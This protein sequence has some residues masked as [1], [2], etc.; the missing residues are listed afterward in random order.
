MQHA[1]VNEL[2]NAITVSAQAL[3]VDGVPGVRFTIEGP[4]SVSE[5]FVTRAEAQAVYEELGRVLS[6]DPGNRALS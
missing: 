3:P 4:S 5:N 1:F 6:E 2:G